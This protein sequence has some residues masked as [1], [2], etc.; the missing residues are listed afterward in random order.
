MIVLLSEPEMLKV[1]E[2]HVETTLGPDCKL[3]S[4]GE[5]S[6]EDSERGYN[7]PYRVPV[8]FAPS[9]GGSPCLHFPLEKHCS[10]T[11]PTPAPDWAPPHHHK[12][13]Y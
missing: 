5:L 1:L 8:A 7:L 9:P 11:E 10:H 6:V 4:E 12:G 3:L 13:L 2:A